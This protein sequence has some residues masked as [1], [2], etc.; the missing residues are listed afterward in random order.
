[1]CWPGAQLEAGLLSSRGGGKQVR[2]K[3]CGR[4]KPAKERVSPSLASQAYL[5]QLGELDSL[6][7]R[8]AP[9]D[10][11]DVQHPVAKLNEGSSVGGQGH[12]VTGAGRE[13]QTSPGEWLLGGHTVSAGTRRGRGVM[14]A[15]GCFTPGRDQASTTLLKVSKGLSF[16]NRDCKRRGINSS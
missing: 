6:L 3:I 16:T 5:V 14:P 1:M 2:P 7:W 9:S 13:E 10:G 15:H 4:A 8:A 12:K 11:G